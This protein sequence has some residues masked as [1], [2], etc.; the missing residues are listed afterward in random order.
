MLKNQNLT[1]LYI[2]NTGRHPCL[3]ER[4]FPYYFYEQSTLSY[5]NLYR[6]VVSAVET[7]GLIHP[8]HSVSVFRLLS[9]AFLTGFCTSVCRIVHC[10]SNA[11]SG[12]VSVWRPAPGPC[13][14]YMGQRNCS[15]PLTSHSPETPTPSPTTT[16]P[17]CCKPFAPH[18]LC[19][20][21]VRPATPT[22]SV[23]H[24]P[25]TVRPA[26]P[27][28]T[29]CCPHVWS[30]GP[31]TT[32]RTATSGCQRIR[33]QR[34]WWL[35]RRSPA[36]SQQLRLWELFRDCTARRRRL[37]TNLWNPTAHRSRLWTLLWNPTA[38]GSRLGT[39]LWGRWQQ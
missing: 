7:P 19:P 28:T 22:A 26:G 12:T 35:F 39:L 10:T 30:A 5:V 2:G 18:P 31:T 11:T 32:F 9:P 14:A 36:G 38:H 1:N 24:R 3:C 4:T 21:H 37:R 29:I 6:I 16:K 8:T 15:S 34:W 20:S 27:A 23:Q 33:H 13:Q 17:L 25:H